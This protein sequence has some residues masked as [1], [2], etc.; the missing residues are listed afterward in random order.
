MSSCSIF[1]S[2]FKSLWSS[3]S[4]NCLSWIISSSAGGTF[5]YSSLWKSEITLSLELQLS[6]FTLKWKI[7]KATEYS[8]WHGTHLDVSGEWK[9]ATLW[10]RRKSGWLRRPDNV[11]IGIPNFL[12]TARIQHKYIVK[13]SLFLWDVLFLPHALQ[14]PRM[15][16]RLLSPFHTFPSRIST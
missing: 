10:M 6:Q 4:S 3:S 13:F 16:L 14:P 1:T 5:S 11:D 7:V 15:L 12:D 8:Q 9:V 2:C